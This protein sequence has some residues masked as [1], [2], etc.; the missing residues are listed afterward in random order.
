[1]TPDQGYPPA[2]FFRDSR[3]M[4]CPEP[5]RGTGPEQSRGKLVLSVV[6]ALVPSSVEGEPLGDAKDK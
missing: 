4:P 3:G 1:M 2:L 5:R 6:E